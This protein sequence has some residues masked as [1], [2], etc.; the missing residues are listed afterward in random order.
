[1]K[2]ENMSPAFKILLQPA[3][4]DDD[5]SGIFSNYIEYYNY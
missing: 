5:S 4:E 1:M 2:S 3:T